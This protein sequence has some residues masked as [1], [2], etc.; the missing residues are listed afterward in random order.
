MQRPRGRPT[1]CVVRLLDDARPPLWR[2]MMNTISANPQL[3]VHGRASHRCLMRCSPLAWMRLMIFVSRHGYA[4]DSTD[5]SGI[6]S[7]RAED[8]AFALEQALLFTPQIDHATQA[9][10]RQEMDAVSADTRLSHS[11]MAWREVC[12]T[13]DRDTYQRAWCSP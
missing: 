3:A 12:L 13:L 7:E 5:V 10:V 8:F 9:A 1:T 2:I 6:T 4:P 11:Q